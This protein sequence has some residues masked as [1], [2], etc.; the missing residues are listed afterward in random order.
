MIIL[1]QMFLTFS[2]PFFSSPHTWEIHLFSAFKNIFFSAAFLFSFGIVGTGKKP[3]SE[4]YKYTYTNWALDGDFQWENIK[5]LFFWM[6][7]FR[8][9]H[10][11]INF[12]IMYLHY[13][14]SY[15]GCLW[16]QWALRKKFNSISYRI[17][18]KYY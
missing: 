8:Y 12:T 3:F 10:E 1:V 11:C 13:I 7:N 5:F 17:I 2:S 16:N 18:E 4:K 14:V 6:M 15:I 9:K